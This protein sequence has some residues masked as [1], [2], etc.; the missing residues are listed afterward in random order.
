MGPEKLY[1]SLNLMDKVSTKEQHDSP[2]PPSPSDKELREARQL[3]NIFTLAWKNYGLYPEDHESTIKSI[4]NLVAVFN[5]FFKKHGDLRLTVEKNS[6]LYKSENVH[7]V[8]LEAPSEDITT[9]LY[10]DGIKWIEFQDGLSLAEIASFFRIAHKYRL[11]AEETEGDIVTALMDEE[12]EYIDFKAVDIYW[13]DLMLMDF[14]QLPPSPPHPEDV[15]DQKETD[16]SQQRTESGKEDTYARS[17]ADPSISEAQLELSNTDYQILQQMV[18]EEE[19]WDITDDLYELLLIILR[20]QTEK[21]KINAVL[22][23]ISEMVVETIELE[24]FDLLVKLFQSLYK[25]PSQETSTGQEWKSPLIDRFFGDLSRPDIFKLISDKLLRLQ[26]SEINKLE[27]LE[28]TFH[29]FSPEIIPFLVPVITQR[30]SNEIQQ[31]VSRVIVQLSQRDIGPLEEIAELHSQKM[32]DKLLTILNSLQGD[33]V[34]EILFKMCEHSSNKVR[35]KAI[36]ELVER[37]PKY[38]PK[39]FSF[40]DDPS[41]EIRACILAAFSKHKS[42]E[43]ENLL[44]NYLEESSVQK[45]FAHI[46]ACYRA[47]GH[48]GSNKAV[49]FL[50]GI[51]LSQGWNSFMG[52]GKP[53][54]RGGA[55]IAL[56]LL[57]TPDAENI[58]QKASKSRYKVIRNAF[59]KRK[60]IGAFS[61]ENSND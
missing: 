6:L 19:R 46:L 9:L 25:L 40:I 7:K 20:N 60:S 36:N 54:F 33:R 38:A 35:R 59:D 53:I 48:C 16:R 52:S 56:A 49:P 3:I 21:D 10:R 42:S 1:N 12:L 50:S 41:K 27:A 26:T 23:F 43:L 30:S 8:S 34:N 2:A 61:G 45:D 17:I 57:D 47:L 5:I 37:D 58:L 4:E 11:F 44:L 15:A 51:L 39:L 14:S 29:Y 55:A 13:Q 28:Q 18:Q 31:L 24:K 22:G 32:G